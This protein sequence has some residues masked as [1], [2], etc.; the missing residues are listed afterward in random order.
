MKKRLFALA[1]VAICLALS[2]YG[3]IAYFT[4]SET[5]RNVVTTGK[6]TADLIETDANGDPF[7]DRSG[8]M[9]G[10][11]AAKV[12]TVKNTGGSPCW[13]RIRIRKTIELAP[14]KSGVPDLSKVRLDFNTADWLQDGDCWYYRYPVEGGQTTSAL[15]TTVSFDASMNN[16][17]AGSIAE[18][19]VSMQAVQTAHNGD[20]VQEAE[21]WPA[22]Q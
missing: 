21:G 16:L 10:A 9:P 11:S 4:A 5:A 2:A 6:I 3:T 14:G 13:I 15:F 7:T 19:E 17:Y 22:F 8:I 12:V 20:T 18:I 1:V